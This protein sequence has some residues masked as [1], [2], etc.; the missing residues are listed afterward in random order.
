MSFQSTNHFSSPNAR[1]EEQVARQV[2]LSSPG[3][4]S[5]PLYVEET[6]D[7]PPIT[8]PLPFI[9]YVPHQSVS[10]ALEE[11]DNETTLVNSVQGVA[12]DADNPISISSSSPVRTTPPPTN[13]WTLAAEAAA[14]R[15]RAER[16]RMRQER[17]V[18]PTGGSSSIASTSRL[19]DP[20]IASTSRLPDP[21]FQPMDSWAQWAAS[22]PTQDNDYTPDASGWGRWGSGSP[23]SRQEPLLGEIGDNNRNGPRPWG[24]WDRLTA[25][26][27]QQEVNDID[28]SL[29]EGRWILPSGEVVAYTPPPAPWFTLSGEEIPFPSETADGTSALAADDL[30]SDHASDSDAAITD[31]EGDDN[32]CFDYPLSPLPTPFPF[33]MPNTGLRTYYARH[34]ALPE[35]TPGWE[36]VPSSDSDEQE[37]EE[38][39]QAARDNKKCD[40]HDS[41]EEQVDEED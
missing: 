5:N 30:E 6:E 7:L 27:E 41:N 37:Q 10:G 1:E 29:T 33:T 26:P 28:D 34:A 3:H 39:E 36:V 8:R 25:S 31:D 32:D 22:S 15:R 20:P 19:P 35:L 4:Q 16:A 24:R 12:G 21:P 9:P 14:I 38:L 23:A 40:E 13:P 11:F 17:M 2:I 18:D